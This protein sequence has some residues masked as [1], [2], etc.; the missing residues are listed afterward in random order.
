[1]MHSFV[2]CK[3]LCQD[4]DEQLNLE[5][6]KNL[7]EIANA[8]KD[9]I[10]V[11]KDQV[12]PYTKELYDVV[13]RNFNR[14]VNIDGDYPLISVAIY[15]NILYNCLTTEKRAIRNSDK[16]YSRILRLLEGKFNVP[17]EYSE[18]TN[19]IL[20]YC[21]NKINSLKASTEAQKNYNYGKFTALNELNDYIFALI[22]Y[23]K[24]NFL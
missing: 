16:V 1:M 23:I 11:Y 5:I 12:N 19:E 2:E 4:V 3:P 15:M 9:L 7:S 14:E 13:K 22:I 20:K 8:F 17:K 21:I 18:Y 24:V 10:T 6:S